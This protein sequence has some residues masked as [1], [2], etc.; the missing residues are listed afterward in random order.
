[1]NKD[2]SSRSS[3]RSDRKLP[4]RYRDDS[5]EV[6]TNV[7]QRTSTVS[8]SGKSQGKEYASAHESINDISS[9]KNPENSHNSEVLSK[10]VLKV[11]C[12]T[13]VVRC[14][15]VSVK[16]ILSGNGAVKLQPKQNRKPKS[17]EE[18]GTTRDEDLSSKMDSKTTKKV[19]RCE[20]CCR[21]FT[22]QSSLQRHVQAATCWKRLAAEADM[23]EENRD[24]GEQML[25]G[26]H[27]RKGRIVC[28]ICEN[29]FVDKY[30][31]L[32][33]RRTHTGERPYHC[34]LCDKK[35]SQRSTLQFHVDTHSGQK[36][37]CSICGYKFT[38]ARSLKRHMYFHTGNKE[39]KRNL[40]NRDFHKI[41]VEVEKPERKEFELCDKEKVVMEMYECEFCKKYFK[42]VAELRVHLRVHTNE[43]PFSC[44]TCG[45]SFKQ[46]CH[47][48]G[49]QKTHEKSETFSCADCGSQFTRAK[50]LQRH[51]AFKMC[52]GGKVLCRK[53]GRPQKIIIIDQEHDEG[54]MEATDEVNIHVDVTDGTTAHQ[55]LENVYECA[56]DIKSSED[57]SESLGNGPIGNTDGQCEQELCGK[58]LVGMNNFMPHKRTHGTKKAFTCNVCSKNFR[59]LNCLN[60]HL[61]THSQ[62]KPYSCENCNKRFKTLRCLLN[63]AGRNCC[64]GRRPFICD[65]CGKSYMYSRYLKTHRCHNTPVKVYS[66]SDCGRMYRR[67]DRL[68]EHM[69]IHTGERPFI[70]NECDKTF[71]KIANFR[72][73]QRVHTGE[74]KYECSHCRKRFAHNSTLRYHESTHKTEKAFPCDQCHRQFP[75]LKALQTHKQ[76]AHNHGV[77]GNRYLCANCGK[78]YQHLKRLL[79]H[80]CEATSGKRFLCGVC[81]KHFDRE[82]QLEIHMRVHTGEKPFKCEKCE[83]GFSQSGG[84]K[85]HMVCHN[86]VKKFQCDL[87]DVK[88]LRMKSLR[89]H[90]LIIHTGVE[91][92]ICKLCG[93]TF[94]YYKALKK[95]EA[96]HE[97][98]QKTFTDILEDIEQAINSASTQVEKSNEAA[99]V[100]EVSEVDHMDQVA[101][102]VIQDDG[103]CQ[104]VIITDHP[105]DGHVFHLLQDPEQLEIDQSIHEIQIQA[106]LEEEEE[107]THQVLTSDV[108]SVDHHEEVVSAP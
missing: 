101:E 39:M 87:C 71:A 67:R 56:N 63:H 80:H 81:F 3:Q 17:K 107:S 41:L 33:H 12:K 26:A 55:V 23:G 50:S 19:L 13:D 83:K 29:S 66:C 99:V 1:M 51:Q 90:K 61:K 100:Q 46:L 84:L 77:T 88:F 69:R 106:Q 94:K 9:S 96:V 57:R 54:K 98:E 95:H 5:I 34:T 47:L 7:L 65:T 85:D 52:S 89:K 31:F 40:V 60:E 82:K 16:R 73:H 58:A 25:E 53:R 102:V 64:T 38:Q 32:V 22:R 45:K 59:L 15:D 27:P 103:T 44:T 92:Q 78:V 14:D 10:R 108:A 2:T 36:H 86:R 24:T 104:E 35:F 49:H 18:I 97:T 21:T 62:D 37:E 93:A 105:G 75:R 28:K 43:R 20:T 48:N 76:V 8:Q 4:A 79:K 70:C 74:K 72:L 11:K 91:P 42:R 6:T 68:I 30:T